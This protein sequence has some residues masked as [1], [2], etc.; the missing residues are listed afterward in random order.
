M[1]YIIPAD[2][3]LAGFDR[4]TNYYLVQRHSVT[5]GRDVIILRG[6]ITI[7]KWNWTNNVPTAEAISFYPAQ[8]CNGVTS[9]RI[10]DVQT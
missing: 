4:K 1:S 2:F 3:L 5:P 9:Q 10:K 7:Q 6:K 8:Y